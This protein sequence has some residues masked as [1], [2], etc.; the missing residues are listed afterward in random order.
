MDLFWRPSALG[1]GSQHFPPNIRYQM[2]NPRRRP[3][4]DTMAH[5]VEDTMEY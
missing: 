5:T 3:P 4:L 2:R 1:W